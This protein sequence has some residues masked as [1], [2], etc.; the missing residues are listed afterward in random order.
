MF[1]RPVLVLPVLGMS[2]LQFYNRK[3]LNS[4]SAVL[5]MLKLYCESLVV[6]D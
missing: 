1:K 6:L 3:I 2:L 4:S 5:C